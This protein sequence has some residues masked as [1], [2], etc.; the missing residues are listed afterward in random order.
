MMDE[1]DQENWREAAISA[2][3]SKGWDFLPF[4]PEEWQWM[5]FNSTGERIAVQ[6]DGT[7]AEDLATLPPP[8]LG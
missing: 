4:G 1:H 3:K 8:R 7:W 6:G 5:K 2:L